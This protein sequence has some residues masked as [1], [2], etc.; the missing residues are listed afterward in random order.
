[1]FA[2]IDRELHR[3][4]DW[5]GAGFPPRRIPQLARQLARH[6]IP[7]HKIAENPAFGPARELFEHVLQMLLK[8]AYNG[9][10]VQERDV[11]RGLLMLR[12]QEA[13]AMQVLTPLTAMLNSIAPMLRAKGDSLYEASLR[14]DVSEAE[15]VAAVRTMQIQSQLLDVVKAAG[16]TAAVPSLTTYPDIEPQH[17]FEHTVF[18]ALLSV[19][20]ASALD[21]NASESGREH[22]ERYAAG[23]TEATNQL[24]RKMGATVSM[25]PKVLGL[26]DAE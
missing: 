19:L 21:V 5:A 20:Y 17:E 26:N 8:A 12:A 3:A 16:I 24:V 14:K 22:I 9:E 11:L 7:E 4:N 15:M 23:D 10:R 1:M 13:A 6:Y 2:K 18:T 25:I